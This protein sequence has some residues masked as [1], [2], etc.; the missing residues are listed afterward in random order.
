MGVWFN[1]EG[2]F[3]QLFS[4]VG[5]LFISPI[6][7]TAIFGFY[8]L[9]SKAKQETMF[10]FWLF[11]VLWLFTAFA[12]H[13]GDVTQ[14]DFWIGGWASIAR[15]MYFPSAVLMIFVSGIFETIH[16]N[17]KVFAAWLVSFAIIISFMANLSCTINHTLMKGDWEELGSGSM[18]VL[19]FPF[20]S[21]GAAE[22]GANVFGIGLLLISLIY[23]AYLF[24]RDR[25]IRELV[26]QQF[27]KI[28]QI[29]HKK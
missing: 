11:I 13:P 9:K 17:R 24:T 2:V 19:P 16:K 23:P 29:V 15:Y 10:L 28:T 12:S 6:L 25:N 20:T 5:I 1:L 3:G 4:P 18:M 7:F 14:R 21:E 27:E 26:Q 8:Y 22:I